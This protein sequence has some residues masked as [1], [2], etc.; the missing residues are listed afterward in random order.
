MTFEKSAEA[1]PARAGDDLRLV[2]QFEGR[3]DRQA[4]R[5]R[6][7]SQA[8]RRKALA[9][10]VERINRRFGAGVVRWAASD[11]GDGR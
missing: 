11:L 10:I 5:T 2:E 3:L 7:Q 6:R 4:N 8:A 9:A 1:V